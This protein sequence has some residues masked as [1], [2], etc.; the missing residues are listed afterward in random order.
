MN[1]YGKLT[2]D[3]VNA[4]T[5]YIER[6]GGFNQFMTLKA[7]LN[8]ILRFWEE[9][10]IDLFH[11]F[12][13]KLILTKQIS[14]TKPSQMLCDEIDDALFRNDKT[15]RLFYNE[16]YNWVR[17]LPDDIRYNCAELLYARL[18]ATNI[19]DGESFEI[20]APDGKKIAVNNGCKVSRI[21]GKIASTFS[22]NGY[23]EFRLAHSLCLNQKKLKG[24]LCISIH[25][26]DYM[27]MSDNYSDW[28]SCMSWQE[29]GDY[30][31]GTVEMMNSPCIVV[32]Y[33]K[34]S[35]NMAIGKGYEWNNKK[36]RQLF[37]V[38]PE[39]ITGIRQYPYHSNE[40]QRAT[41]DWLRELVEKSGVW[42]TYDDTPV[43]VKNGA[44]NARANGEEFYLNFYTRLMYNDFYSS[45]LSYISSRMPENFEYCFSGNSECVICGEDLSGYYEGDLDPAALTCESCECRRRCYEC[46]D[47]I[48]A[49]EGYEIDG[50]YYCYNCY[51]NCFNTCSCCGEMVHN[52]DL[53]PIY[54]RVN[55]ND[56]VSDLQY[57]IM[58]CYNCTNSVYFKENF[59][60]ISEVTHPRYC[61]QTRQV[62]DLKNLTEEGLNAFDIYNPEVYDK[63]HQI[64][65][66]NQPKA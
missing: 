2:N 21:L 42:G 43:E 19:Y 66:E 6:Y 18:L 30:R 8:H 65:L 28:S 34:S 1:M 49:E 48:D 17:L 27:T 9:N 40:L 51:E 35:E 55:P 14:I 50:H 61:W 7:P 59:G 45:H 26:L 32:A 4:I 64:V 38:T 29:T 56:A 33:L 52:N 23:E 10:K 31:Q 46:G 44:N 20:P 58:V 13:E 5:T 41:L 53:E 62:V 25:P 47:Y 60:E 12:G 54:L 37:I 16:Y 24:E 36:W 11:I 63:Y 39:I 22:I 57:C 3:D 15:G